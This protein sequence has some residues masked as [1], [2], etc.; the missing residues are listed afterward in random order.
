MQELLVAVL[1][2]AAAAFMGRRIYLQYQ[3][4]SGC[5]SAGCDAC[6]PEEKKIE[7]PAHF[8]N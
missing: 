7:L 1:F 3:A 4:K 5:A 8:K 2:L 6:A